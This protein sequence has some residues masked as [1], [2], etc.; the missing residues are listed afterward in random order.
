MDGW[1]R[2]FVC[3]IATTT[4]EVRPQL[5]A[6]GS[7]VGCLTELEYRLRR[8]TSGQ[9]ALDID[10]LLSPTDASRQALIQSCLTHK[11]V[12]FQ[13]DRLDASDRNRMGLPS[14]FGELLVDGPCKERSQETT[15]MG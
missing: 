9:T 2:Y 7:E 12:V 5:R 8:N 11:V 15:T 10:R 14:I 13:G 3:G 1:P 6:L 4:A